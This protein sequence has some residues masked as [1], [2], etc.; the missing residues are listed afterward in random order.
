MNRTHTCNA[1]TSEN[2]GERVILSGWVNSRRDLGG[3]IFIDLRDREG[4]TQLVINPENASDVAD[5]CRPIREEWV[6]TVCGI[7]GARPDDMVNKK[8]GTGKIEVNLEKIAIENKSQP[9]PYHFNDAQ[10]SEDLRLKYRYIEMRKTKLG[11]YLR[12]RHDITKHIRDYFD[13]NGFIEVET[14]I[15]S[16]ST[17]EGARDYLVPSRVFPGQF[18]ALPQA[19]QQYKQILMVGGLERYFQM[20]HCFRDEDL[21]A[22]RQPEFTQIDVE[23]SF[24]TEEDIY[25]LVEGL[26]TSIFR[27]IKQIDIDT[28]FPR[29]SYEEAMF[30]YG[31]DKPDTRFKMRLVDLSSVVTHSGFQV[32]KNAIGDGGKVMAINAKGLN[33]IAS[34]KTIDEWNDIAKLMKAKGLTY[35]KIEDDGTIKSPIA[36]FLTE[37]E[38]NDI[39]NLTDATSGDI[40]LIVAD[41]FLTAAQALGRLRTEIAEAHGMI[42]DNTYNFL[43]VNKFPLLELDEEAASFIPIH[44]PFTSPVKADIPL[45]ET[46][47]GG[48]KAQAYDV[49]LNGVELGG[50]SIRI[51]DAELQQRMFEILNIS[52]TEINS[53]FGHLLDALGFGAPPH[54]GLAIGFDRLVM[55]LTG[56]P[57]IRDVIAFPKTTKSSCLLMDSPS[58]VDGQQLNELALTIQQK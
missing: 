30:Q 46:N 14:P 15:L 51:H 32:F 45:L 12:L 56:A 2:I 38:I 19:P 8:I 6:L 3:L 39:T 58:Q 4:I 18:F 40:V 47:P 50:G 35:L 24:I 29:L 49:V 44:H 13:E 42:P 41:A 5:I 25:E 28:P 1:L 10:A 16:K 33:S 57:S 26:M 21:R 11:S 27:E 23:M 31:S 54:G 52:D 22:D 17:P 34:R 9:M 48:V 43:W 37:E 36:K 7:V 53:K 55:L 20:A